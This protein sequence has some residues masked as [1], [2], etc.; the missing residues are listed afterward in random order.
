MILEQKPLE[1][2][3][4]EKCDSLAYSFDIYRYCKL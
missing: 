2:E 4:E 3:I 1:P